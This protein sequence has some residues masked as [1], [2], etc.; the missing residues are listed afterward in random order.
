VA[1]QWTYDQWRK[2]FLHTKAYQVP[3]EA[4]NSFES[5][6]V[7]SKTWVFKLIGCYF[8]E[9]KTPFYLALVFPHVTIGQFQWESL[10]ATQFSF[11]YA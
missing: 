6:L 10:K 5:D 11:P 8:L 2:A 9:V 7:A 3:T 1:K 4:C